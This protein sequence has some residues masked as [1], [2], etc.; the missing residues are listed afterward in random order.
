MTKERYSGGLK[1]GKENAK[2][3]QVSSVEFLES[4]SLERE[5]MKRKRNS[6]FRWWLEGEKEKGPLGRNQRNRI[7]LRGTA[8]L[9][10]PYDLVSRL[11]P[12]RGR[13]IRTTEKNRP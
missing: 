8:F 7:G 5:K 9:D 11:G 4:R 3:L 12:K 1:S 6:L 13:P 2:G 10:K